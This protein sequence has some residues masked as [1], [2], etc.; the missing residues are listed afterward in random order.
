MLNRFKQLTISIILFAIL[1]INCDLQQQQSEPVNQ[2]AIA[3]ILDID[4]EKIGYVGTI[5]ERNVLV[6]LKPHLQIR[7]IDQISN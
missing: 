5:G 7:N 4:D 3:P 2:F 1:K 6:D